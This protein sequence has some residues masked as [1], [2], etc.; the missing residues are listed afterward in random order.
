L[1]QK[2]LSNK[3]SCAGHQGYLCTFR[4]IP[5]KFR[6]EKDATKKLVKKQEKIPIKIVVK[7]HGKESNI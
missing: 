1:F 4:K 7:L 5:G 3:I 6:R 2:L